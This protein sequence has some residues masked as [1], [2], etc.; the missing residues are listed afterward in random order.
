MVLQARLLRNSA[1]CKYNVSV[2]GTATKIMRSRTCGLHKERELLGLS[3]KEKLREAAKG[4]G[5]STNLF[6]RL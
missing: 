6:H 4:V 3:F 1:A 2:F 5:S